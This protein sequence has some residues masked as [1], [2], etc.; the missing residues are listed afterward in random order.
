MS[1]DAGASQ[2]TGGFLGG[3]TESE[4][5]G[6][7]ER[8]R[9]RR[10]SKGDTL[11]HEGDASD[12][13][14]VLLKGRAKI[15]YDSEAGTEV[16]LGVRDPGELLGE[17]SALD[18]APRSA[19]VTA[20]EPVE[21]LVLTAGAFRMYLES[22]PR[23]AL[24]LIQ[25]LMSRLR[26][27]DVKRVEFGTYDSV[28]RVARRLV[29]LAERFGRAGPDGVVIE[30][31]ITQ[32]E[33]AGWTGTSRESVAKALHALRRLEWVDTGRRQFVIRDLDALRRRGM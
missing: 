10:Y 12:W 11:F 16:V 33:L 3:L 17:L 4:R 31:P 15:S 5:D 29:E 21:A 2:S 13:V 32:Q 26:D 9:R 28:G 25:S 18:G 19:T 20:M 7:L 27:A 14:A 6:L 23:L 22:Y 24:Q 30:L 1:K 8:G